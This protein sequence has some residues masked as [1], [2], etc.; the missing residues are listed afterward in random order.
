MLSIDAVLTNLWE[1][2]TLILT[3]QRRKTRPEEV[4]E[5]TQGPTDNGGKSEDFIR[6]CIRLMGVFSFVSCFL[7]VVYVSSAT[8]SNTPKQNPL[9]HHAVVFREKKRGW[10]IKAVH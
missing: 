3:S 7:L 10:N 1:V 6:G 5:L 9:K 8:S 2:N 4:R